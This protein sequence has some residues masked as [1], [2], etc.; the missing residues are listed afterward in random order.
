MK[1]N[2]K[3][4]IIGVVV[5]FSL[6]MIILLSNLKPFAT[7]SNLFGNNQSLSIDSTNISNKAVNEEISNKE[8]KIVFIIDNEKIVMEKSVMMKQIDKS[9]INEIVIIDKPSQ[10]HIAKYGKEVLNGLIIISTNK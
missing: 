9:K 1:S 2:Y 6:I 5:I 10:E 8:N 4:Y 7:L 3:R